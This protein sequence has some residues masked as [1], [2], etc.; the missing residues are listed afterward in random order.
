[1]ERGLKR[2]IGWKG[3]GLNPA[4]RGGGQKWVDKEVV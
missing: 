4:D 3:T 1:M 2:R